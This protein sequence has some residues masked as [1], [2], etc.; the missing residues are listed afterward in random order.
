MGLVSYSIISLLDYVMRNICN[1]Y[2]EWDSKFKN[3]S[4]FAMAE[5]AFC[6]ILALA[7][8]YFDSKDHRPIDFYPIFFGFFV[9]LFY[10]Y[11]TS[12]IT[13]TIERREETDAAFN[14][15]M[16]EIKNKEEA[17][18]EAILTE[19]N[20]VDS[21]I[22]ERI[23]EASIALKKAQKELDEARNNQKAEVNLVK[24]NFEKFF[25]KFPPTIVTLVALFMF[26]V[27]MV[28]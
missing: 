17:V 5:S 19:N 6:V 26:M 25:K 3:E 28:T 27:S 21:K 20:A 12:T 11:F 9:P 16:K 22:E 24:K 10:A 14:K 23:N 2:N 13:K 18:S 8:W 15:H 1:K 7:I 4:K